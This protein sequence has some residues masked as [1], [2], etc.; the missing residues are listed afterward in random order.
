MGLAR[1]L[2]L[3]V[4]RLLWF[5]WIGWWLALAYLILGALLSSTNVMSSDLDDVTKNAWAIAT[6]G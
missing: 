6:L 2:V 5:L 1:S 3:G 4:V